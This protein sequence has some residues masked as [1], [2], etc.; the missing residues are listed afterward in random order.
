[1][2][3]YLWRVVVELYL[4]PRGSRGRVA[5]AYVINVGGVWLYF[6]RYGS[7]CADHPPAASSAAVVSSLRYKRV[8]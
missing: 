8:R 3:V 6:A 1:M 2:V 7:V 5:D 4:A